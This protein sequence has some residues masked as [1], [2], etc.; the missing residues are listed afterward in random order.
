METFEQRSDGWIV[1]ES[2]H[3][4][5]SIGPKLAMAFCHDMVIWGAGQLQNPMIFFP[6]GNFRWVWWQRI[7]GWKLSLAALFRGGVQKNSHSSHATIHGC[8]SRV[9]MDHCTRMT[10]TQSR[11]S[12]GVFTFI[13]MRNREAHLGLENRVATLS[14]QSSHIGVLTLQRM[15][16]WSAKIMQLQLASQSR[17]SSWSL[18]S[19][20]LRP[21]VLVKPRCAAA[22]F[23]HCRVP[24][25]DVYGHLCAFEFLCRGCCKV[26]NALWSLGAGAAAGISMA[27]CTL[28]LGCL[29][30]CSCCDC[31]MPLQDVYGFVRFCKTL[32]S[33]LVLWMTRTNQEDVSAVQFHFAWHESHAQGFHLR[34]ISAWKERECSVFFRMVA[35][36][37]RGYR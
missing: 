24:L 5:N 14:I 36:P 7:L 34:P 23:F 30:R 25:Q 16:F 1:G 2:H 15:G 13:S 17:F 4:L 28:E 20:L 32:C 31:R 3:Q 10:H 8:L 12:W 18:P 29:R 22:I 11:S 33:L 26:Q 9:C 21:W 6:K 27:M 19:L 35:E 37:N